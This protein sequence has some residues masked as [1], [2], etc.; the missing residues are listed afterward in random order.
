MKFASAVKRCH[1]SPIYLNKKGFTVIE[2]FIALSVLA[3]ISAISIYYYTDYID[4]A[5]MTV[6]KTNEKLVNDALNRY[7]KE[8]MTY[9]K[10]HW[11]YDS[12]EDISKNINKGLDNELLEYFVNKKVS[13][14]FT[15]GSGVKS[16]LVYFRVTEPV[17]RGSDIGNVDNS[18]NTGT[19]KMSKNLRVADKEYMVHEI[20]IVESDGGI[21]VNTFNDGDNFT[22]PL[23]ANSVPIESEHTGPKIISQDDDF[24]LKMVC[25]PPGTFLMGAPDGETGK[26][27][28]ENLHSVTITTQFLIGRYEITQK[29]YQK[30]MGT[31]PSG[32]KTSENHPVENVTRQN[33]LDFCEKLNNDYSRLVP[34]G[35]KF[36][37]PTEAQWEYACRA[38]TTTALNNGTSCTTANLKLVG[39]FNGNSKI[40]NTAQTHPV[41]EKT[42]NNWGIYDMHG[43]VEE[44]IKDLRQYNNDGIYSPY[45]ED[46]NID[47]IV[48]EGNQRCHRGGNY[49]STYDR[50]RSASRQG[51]WLSNKSNTVGFRVVLTKVHD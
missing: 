37:L 47:P 23:I 4:D 45:S 43:N 25:C 11:L 34:Y 40:N 19:W 6:R 15:E 38:G 48:T 2:I 16:N 18:F 51:S 26:K 41:G 21:P 33:A 35:Y 44:I 39:W 30:V 32:F 20:R 5:R 36:D 24:E 13:E 22:F 42:P 3:V 50:C 31:N 29:Q 9:P 46:D 8:H 14:I 12:I 27:T 7:Y 28:N 49:N 1:H 10:Y 17:K